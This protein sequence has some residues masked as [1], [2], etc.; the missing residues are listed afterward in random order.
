VWRAA[1]RQGEGKYFFHGDLLITPELVV[2]GADRATKAGGA[3]V[4]A[5]DRGTGAERWTVPAGAGVAAALTGRERQ[6]FAVALDGELW[7]LDLPTGKRQWSVP[8]R[9]WAWEGP[10]V[11]EGRVFAGAKDGTLS[12]LDA[13]TG[14]VQWQTSLGGEISTSVVRSGDSLYVG[15]VDGQFHQVDARAGK[16]IRSHRLDAS[17]R[18]RS[19]PIVT[20]EAVFVLL[21]DASEDSRAIVS[22][23]RSLERIQWR[24]AAPDKWSTT[25]LSVSGNTLVVGTRTGDVL[26]YCTSDGTPA[27]T[28]T[29]NG[30][31]RAIGGADDAT[32]VGTVEGRLFALRPPEACAKR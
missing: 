32:Y 31:V 4:H 24:V 30:T 25:R 10:A 14:K 17:L 20:G 23:D 29:V 13:A 19:V 21:M 12:S 3:Q 1:V 2:A 8:L 18:P 6:V 11:G 16:V 28:H 22:L 15:T 9:T 5:F 26:T 7:S 27:W